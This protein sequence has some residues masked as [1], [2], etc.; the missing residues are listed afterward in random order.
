MRH[1]AEDARWPAPTKSEA[2]HHRSCARHSRKWS[3]GIEPPPK[4]AADSE[5]SRPVGAQVTRTMPTPPT[6]SRCGRGFRRPP[7]GFK[8]PER[9]R[10]GLRCRGCRPR[11]PAQQP[12]AH[13][14]LPRER[15]PATC[16]KV[17]PGGIEAPPKPSPDS[18]T[19]DSEGSRATGRASDPD[20]PDLSDLL[21]AWPDLSAGVRQ[22]IADLARAAR[23][24][25]SPRREPDGRSR[26]R[27]ALRSPPEGFAA[28]DASP[29]DGG[30]SAGSGAAE[31]GAS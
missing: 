18:T 11:A 21:A 2:N 12:V 9:R 13:E 26:G 27:E 17:E 4:P 1:G 5:G 30:T 22:A 7:G 15:T 20:D 25:P 31:G 10:H 6:C 14:R 29:N 28:G 19:P 8:Q 3:Q 23:T 24:Q 16:I